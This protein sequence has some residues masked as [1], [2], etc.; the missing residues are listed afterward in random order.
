MINNWYPSA[1]GQW[2]FHRVNI[3]ETLHEFKKMIRI[4]DLK[5]MRIL[6]ILLIELS[7]RSLKI[8]KSMHK[9]HMIFELYDILH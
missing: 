5:E 3:F 1:M 4:K 6:M 9:W 7:K 2:I 8:M